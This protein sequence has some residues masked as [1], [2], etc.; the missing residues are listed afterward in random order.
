MA[1]D[2]LIPQYLNQ[3]EDARLI[4]PVEMA[5]AL[6]IRIDHDADGDA[7]VVKNVQGNEAVAARSTNDAIPTDGTNK[8]VGCVSSEASK[9][10]Y[11]FLYNSTGLHGI[12][13]YSV[14]NNW[15]VK[16]YE[17]DVLNFNQDGFV[18]ADVV[19]N[20]FQE[21]LLY[22]TDG[23]NEPRK[24]N[25]SRA[26]QNG[27]ADE[28]TSGSDFVKNLYLTACK[29]PPQTP[30]TFEFVTDP[31]VK[32]NNLRESCFQFA[33]QY[34]YDDG[35][36]SALSMYSK[37]AVSSTHL[38]Y[39]QTSTT[40]FE[41]AN[42]VLRL[43][44]QGS[45]GPVER[46][47]I[48]ARKNNDQAFYKVDEVD[49][50]AGA[51]TVDFLNDKSYPVLS[52][53]EANKLYDA[54]PRSASTQTFSN[55]RL[56][57]GNYVEGFPNITTRA[58][59]SPVYHSTKGIP[60]VNG[61]VST[62]TTSNGST[63]AYRTALRVF[64]DIPAGEN[65]NKSLASDA[66]AR[67]KTYD[68]YQIRYLS[69]DIDMS[70]VPE[71]IEIESGSVSF[72]VSISASEVSFHAVSFRNDS[73]ESDV[74]DAGGD[75]RYVPKEGYFKKDILVGDDET[76]NPGFD[77]SHSDEEG[78][79][80]LLLFAPFVR[81]GNDDG[82][83]DSFTFN[84]PNAALRGTSTFKN[85]VPQQNIEFAVDF[86]VSN[87]SNK[88]QLVNAIRSEL[89]GLTSNI[90]VSPES[91]PDDNW[92]Q[93]D[94]GTDD[95]GRASK[96]FKGV[97]TMGYFL[98]ESGGFED[99]DFGTN[100]ND[101]ASRLCYL[102]FEGGMEFT[103]L[104]ATYDAGTDN[105]RCNF[106]RTDFDFQASH[107]AYVHRQDIVAGDDNPLTDSNWPSANNSLN[108]DY[109]DS[110]N[111]EFSDGL[112][113]NI[114]PEN[115]DG[116]GEEGTVKYWNG[117]GAK[118]SFSFSG[119]DLAND[120]SITDT[121]DSQLRPIDNIVEDGAGVGGAILTSLRGMSL[122]GF[123]L[124]IQAD[125]STTKT[126]KSSA[127]HDFGVVYFDDR[128][129]PSFVQKI[130]SGEVARFGDT[131]R[132]GFNGR[133]L[134]D[135][136]LTHAPPPWATSYAPVYS[137]N[138]TYDMYL[139]CTVA[140]AGLP[141]KTSFTD[142][143]SGT[144]DGIRPVIGSVGGA[145]LSQYI[146][147]SLRTLEGKSV[148]YKESKGGDLEY[149]FL[150]GDKLRIIQYTDPNGDVLRP[151]S[152]FTVTDFK[153]FQDNEENPV[154]IFINGT[155]SEEFR[156]TG[157][158][159]ILRDDGVENFDRS[160]IA[161]GKDFWS[162]QV[163]VEIF[164]PKKRMDTQVFYEVG[165][166]RDI[167][168]A[169]S[170]LTHA[171]DRDNST[172]PTFTI[173]TV[174]PDRFRSSQRLYAGDLVQKSGISANNEV[175]ITGVFEDIDTGEY[176]YSV[177]PQLSSFPTGYS[178]VTVATGNNTPGSIHHGVI[179]LTH[180]DSYLR[181]REQMVNKEQEITT[182]GITLRF[183]PSLVAEHTYRVFLVESPNVSDFFESN[184][185]D[186][187]RPHLENPEAEELLRNT[188]L[189][190]SNRYS[191]DNSRL[192]LSEFNPALFP[193]KDYNPQ[194]GS[195]THLID[196]GTGL[197]VMHEK[198]VALQPVERT[199]IESAGDGQ[200]VTSSNVLG[201]ERYYAGTFGPGR[202]PESVV[203]RFGQVYFCDAESGRIMQL[204]EGQLLPISENKMESYFENLFAGLTTA[205]AYPKIPCGFDPE[206]N[207][208][209]ASLL[210]LPSINITVGSTVVGIVP[211]RTALTDDQT[212]VDAYVR[213][214]FSNTGLSKLD[215]ANFDWDEADLNFKWD[216]YG[217]G[218]AYLDLLSE[219]VGMYVE[220]DLAGSSSTIDVDVVTSDGLHTA[221]ATYNLQT[222]ELDLPT[223]AVLGSNN[224]NVSI[225]FANRQAQAF[226]TLAYSPKIQFWL[227][228]YSFSPEMYASIQNKFFSFNNGAMYRH[229]TNA[230]Y[231]TFYGAAY[232]SELTIISRGHPSQI[233]AYNA[234]SL[235]GDSSNWSVALSNNTQ[236][237][238][239]GTTEWDE[240]EG[241]YYTHIG[242]DEGTDNDNTSHRIHLGVIS[243]I[244]GTKVTMTSR[245]SNLPFGIG[246][247]V[248]QTNADKT[249]IEDASA[250]I[251]S[252]DSRTAITVS[253]VSNL[254][255]GRD[256]F[257]YSAARSNGDPIRDYYLQAAMTNAATTAHELHAVN[258]NFAP[259]PLHNENNK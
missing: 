221:E 164:R 238:T 151:Y 80:G 185:T 154:D 29:R 198:K 72:L 139:Q 50:V 65:K 160:A 166:Q 112:N 203:S 149:K 40:L 191:L 52:D 22:F 136:R 130:A 81:D 91:T 222:N 44:V 115:A 231:N 70:Q 175:T 224:S 73:S 53:E 69:F 206:N 246:D 148:S 147:V 1:I 121:N 250:T 210:E 32:H 132:L 60:V 228:R 10:I 66:V 200:L 97:T 45:N 179:T 205:T 138:T 218:T 56:F 194:Y 75:V 172:A 116:G 113:E 41:S 237:A 92:S 86:Q 108:F 128:N 83:L 254:V 201:S 34:V 255:V 236:A 54:V 173:T 43:T 188:S 180:G 7:G 244:D 28:M 211:V 24:I 161:G 94:D 251:S 102:W 245:I 150:K 37:L 220:P 158:W 174:G 18:K 105:I 26:L 196:E 193:F 68:D 39:D 249:D 95:Y 257:A 127:T 197:V 100:A 182:G 120:S 14:S 230:A 123:V 67:N 170:V 227:T 239:I 96:W 204:K 241:M 33:Y 183:D 155:A 79:G 192:T 93:T 35:E 8:V 256:L 64:G 126:F 248:Y 99:S 89:I 63:D 124:R 165:E 223:T 62:T 110:D 216:E 76:V 31:E 219:S 252:V 145:G 153:Y 208:F 23:L 27:Y 225:T 77:N 5:D 195:I 226:N 212:D 141:G 103:I 213:P 243:A 259:S 156:R 119:S 169:N 2:K 106:Y 234:M 214:V 104:N 187:G 181:P 74:F 157:W 133:S 190:Y 51:F 178:G 4:K 21:D 57:Y 84:K 129:R 58:S 171:G 186:L 48:Y 125:V 55:N 189:T 232:N 11:F 207:E 240:R 233:K 16:L 117:Q 42:N 144:G 142:I 168:T 247:A 162:Q 17:D 159:L 199:L 140:E 101:K 122:E 88:T 15:Y 152:E 143:Y 9:C 235:E 242:R 98:D 36:V 78:M 131:S 167:V 30:I 137:K 184:A 135:L 217:Q 19:I 111:V 146:M 229:N 46:I 38:A 90:S 118:F 71:G 163:V 107:L 49:N 25:A 177:S 61:D 134:M 59:A 215:Q 12:Y 176:L 85:L 109:A 87:I 114:L 253:D 258:F 209:V 6:N 20:Q 3:D 202:N 47:R 82:T 13:R